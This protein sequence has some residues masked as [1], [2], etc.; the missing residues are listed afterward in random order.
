M[1]SDF[2]SAFH[3]YLD[4]YDSCLGHSMSFS[5]DGGS[6]RQIRWFV[7]LKVLYVSKKFGTKVT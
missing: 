5:G 3:D 7:D 2:H 4:K 6:Q 1:L